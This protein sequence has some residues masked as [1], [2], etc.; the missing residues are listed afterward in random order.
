MM[1]PCLN[2]GKAHCNTNNQK[3]PLAVGIYV[4]SVFEVIVKL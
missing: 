2:G 1:L 4:F 3:F